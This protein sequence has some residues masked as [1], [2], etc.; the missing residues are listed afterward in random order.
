MSMKTMFIIMYDK[1]DTIKR[2][3]GDANFFGHKV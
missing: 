3:K 2:F 1:I